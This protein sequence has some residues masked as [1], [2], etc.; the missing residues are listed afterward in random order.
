MTRLLVLLIC[1]FVVEARLSGTRREQRDRTRNRTRDRVRDQPRNPSFNLDAQQEGVVKKERP[2]RN[3]RNYMRDRVDVDGVEQAPG[4]KALEFLGEIQQAVMAPIGGQIAATQVVPGTDENPEIPGM[5]PVAILN[6]ARDKSEI[7]ELVTSPEIG[8]QSAATQAAPGTTEDSDIPG[9]DPVAILND[10]VRAPPEMDGDPLP[11][12]LV[13][14]PETDG[15]VEMAMSQTEDQIEAS[16]VA[17]GTIEVNDTPDMDPVAILNDEREP[18]PPIDD[19]QAPP[20]IDGDPPIVLPFG[21]SAENVVL[22]LTSSVC[23]TSQEEA[24]QNCNYLPV[25]KFALHDGGIST[26]LQM[27]EPECVRRCDS[28][29]SE[30]HC[31]SHQQCFHFIFGCECAGLSTDGGECQPY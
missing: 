5:D 30:N 17:P 25:C 18:P 1:C 26:I 3:G 23:A 13:D 15:G 19:V 20:E 16:Q 27:N 14:A 12:D 8:S 31:M 21:N 10:E 22:Q 9:T 6:D 4:P 28:P 2:I 29:L 11:E 7:S 24:A